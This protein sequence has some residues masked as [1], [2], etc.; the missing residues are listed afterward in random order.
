MKKKQDAKYWSGYASALSDPDKDL[1]ALNKVTMPSNI[2]L[3]EIHECLD[4]V[5]AKR[6][7][8]FSGLDLRSGYFQLPI[9]K[10]SQEKTAFTCLSLGQQF[11]CKVTSQGLTSAPASFARTMGEP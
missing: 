1:R 11:C 4:R 2:R 8:V 9:E 6:P 5:A 3:P 10:N 7:T